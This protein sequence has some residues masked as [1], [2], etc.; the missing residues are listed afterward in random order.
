VNDPTAFFVQIFKD[1]GIA[2]WYTDTPDTSPWKIALGQFP[3]RPDTVILLNEASG[4]APYPSLLVNFPS[5]Q[6]LIRGNQSG[7][8]ETRAKLKEAID[9]VLGYTPGL[10]VGGDTLQ[11]VQQLGD[12]MPLGFDQE[13]RPMFSANF[14]LIVL[15][16]PSAL[17][18]RAP[19]I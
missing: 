1:A 7:R 2:Q 19:I 12:V 15:P 6:I 8:N 16:A 3:P 5:V 4:L 14:S 13:K 17:S 11:S 9:C 10:I 18:H